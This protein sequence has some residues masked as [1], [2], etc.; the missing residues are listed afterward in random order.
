MDVKDKKRLDVV[1]SHD[2]SRPEGTGYS[3]EIINEYVLRTTINTFWVS[4]C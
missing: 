2:F 3:Y 4:F 1:E